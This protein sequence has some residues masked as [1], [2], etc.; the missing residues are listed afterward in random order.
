MKRIAIAAVL[1]LAALPA[2]AQSAPPAA[3]PLTKAVIS[4]TNNLNLT[5]L[6]QSIRAETAEK[7]AAEAKAEVARLREENKKLEDQL[8][9]A[10]AT[11]SASLPPKTP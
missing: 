3:D 1:W 4:W 7:E 2:F 11:P 9:A 10:K 5:G 8:A 6:Q